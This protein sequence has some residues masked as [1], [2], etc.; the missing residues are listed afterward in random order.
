MKE[1]EERKEQ[2]RKIGEKRRQQMLKGTYYSKLIDI[3]A[4]QGCH[5]LPDGD[6]EE[7]VFSGIALMQGTLP[8]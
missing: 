1:E 7:S 6:G 4:L 3:L 2:E 8:A 5:A